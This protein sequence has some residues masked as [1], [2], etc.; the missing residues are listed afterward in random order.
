MYST[1]S[2]AYEA[3]GSSGF[4]EYASNPR[5]PSNVVE[6]VNTVRPGAVPNASRASI[7]SNTRTSIHLR[8]YRDI[9][10]NTDL[11]PPSRHKVRREIDGGTTPLQVTHGDMVRSLSMENGVAGSGAGRRDRR[12]DED[13]SKKISTTETLSGVF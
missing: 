8:S 4:I 1:F 10:V 11:G 6:T 12:C 9:G 13:D 3:K 2:W 5:K 7:S